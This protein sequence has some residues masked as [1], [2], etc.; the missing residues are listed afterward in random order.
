MLTRQI[1]GD[2]GERAAVEYMKNNG[3]EI[4]E[5]NYSSKY[6][7]IDIVARIDEYVVFVEVKSRKSSAF[8][9]PREFV[10][11]RKQAKIKKTAYK[12]IDE[13][14]VLSPVRFD[15]CEIYHIPGEEYKVKCI[16]YIEG[17]FE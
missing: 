13:R 17:A 4:V 6:G 2:A 8:G 14:K 1:I 15:V 7:E 9:E 10:D 5:T 12:Y 11:C 16:N 3:F